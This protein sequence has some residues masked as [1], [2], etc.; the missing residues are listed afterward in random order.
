MKWPFGHHG[1]CCCIRA[2][3]S[4]RTAGGSQGCSVSAPLMWPHLCYHEGWGRIL[5]Y[6]CEKVNLLLLYTAFSL[7][8]TT[9]QKSNLCPTMSENSGSFAVVEGCCNWCWKNAAHSAGLTHYHMGYWDHQGND[10]CLAEVCANPRQKIRCLWL[11][12]T[13]IKLTAQRPFRMP[14]H[15]SATVRVSASWQPILR[16]AILMQQKGACFYW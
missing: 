13:K 3:F 1:V 14:H 4:F 15:G 16:E 6:M 9:L 12:E 5:K 10:H 11:G 8:R 2:I 7:S